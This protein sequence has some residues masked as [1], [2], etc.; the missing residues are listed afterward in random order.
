MSGP[1][2]VFL[3]IL[4]MFRL[5]FLPELEFKEFYSHS[6][7]P[8]VFPGT[9]CSGSIKGQTLAQRIDYQIIFQT[10]P[11]P[12]QAKGLSMDGLGSENHRGPSSVMYAQSSNRM[13][14]SP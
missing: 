13:P 4:E 11:P 6:A 9:A 14:N 2:N 10:S 1:D 12:T 8:A 5:Q 3:R 7:A